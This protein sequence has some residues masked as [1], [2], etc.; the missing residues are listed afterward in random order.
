MK[1]AQDERDLQAAIAGIL[2]NSAKDREIRLAAGRYTLSTTTLTGNL[3]LVGE[4][5]VVLVGPEEAPLF[6]VSAGT[7]SLEGITIE[8]AAG[9]TGVALDAGRVEMREVVV[10]GGTRGVVARGR[11]SLVAEDCAIESVASLSVE[12]HHA[13][14]AELKRV[15]IVTETGVAI[16][17]RGASGLRAEHLEVVA[18]PDKDAIIVERGR[19][20]E[21]VSCRV[22]GGHR[23]LHAKSGQGGRLRDCVFEGSAYPCLFLNGQSKNRPE[24]L[25]AERCT[26]RGSQ[27]GSGVF[28]ERAG[29][30]DT[31]L[32]VLV[33][34]VFERCAGAGAAVEHGALLVVKGG[35]FTENR[36]GV[37]A[38]DRGVL[39]IADATIEGGA[40]S[41]QADKRGTLLA[42]HC[43]FTNAS[44]V[45]VQVQY[46]GQCR[47]DGGCLSTSAL[48]F[49]LGDGWLGIHNATVE[50]DDVALKVEG[51][52]AVVLRS[53][54]ASAAEPAVAVVS[55]EV[56]ADEEAA[57]GGPGVQIF[58][59][60]SGDAASADAI[61]ALVR[62]PPDAWRNALL[63]EGIDV[64]TWSLEVVLEGAGRVLDGGALRRGTLEQLREDGRWF[65]RAVEWL[66]VDPALRGVTTR[67]ARADTLPPL[68]ELLSELDV[69]L[70]DAGSDRFKLRP[71]A[72]QK[73]LTKLATHL[74]MEELP[75][76]LVV[77]F[78]WHDGQSSPEPDHGGLQPGKTF[79]AMSLE[80]IME[81]AMDVH[82]DATRMPPLPSTHLPLLAYP[83]GLVTYDLADGHLYLAENGAPEVEAFDNGRTLGEWIHNVVTMRRREAHARELASTPP[84]ELATEDQ[85]VVLASAGQLLTQNGACLELLGGARPGVG[86][87]A[88]HHV[89]RYWWDVYTSRDAATTIEGLIE[90]AKTLLE[91]NGPDEDVAWE[92]GRAAFVAGSAYVAGLVGR[93]EAWPRMVQ[94]ARLLRRRFVS[95]EHFGDAYA[96]HLGEWEA[97]LDPENAKAHAR[98]ERLNTPFSRAYARLL[99]TGLW[100]QVPWELASEPPAPPEL[101]AAKT[102]KVTP[103]GRGDTSTLAV[104]LREASPGDRL[105]VSPGRHRGGHVAASAFLE[106]V[107]DGEGVVIESLDDA[108]CFA[109]KGGTLILEN[110]TMRAIRRRSGRGRYAV[111]ID[112]GHLQATRCRFEAASIGLLHHNGV[113]RL[114]DC[115]VEGLDNVAIQV[116]RGCFVAER[117]KI[118]RAAVINVQIAGSDTK[119][120]L[121]ECTLAE[122]HGIGLGAYNGAEVEA[123]SCRIHGHSKSNVVVSAPVT[124]IECELSR[125]GE[126]AAKVVGDGVLRLLG[127][128]VRDAPNGSCVY[129]EATSV[130]E[131]R[132]S[133]LH[134]SAGSGLMLTGRAQGRVFQSE[135]FACNTA[136][137]FAREG[138]AGIVVGSRI[139]DCEFGPG[140]WVDGASMQLAGCL[141]ERNGRCGVEVKADGAARV[142]SCRFAGNEGAGVR[143]IEGGSLFLH[144][145]TIADHPEVGI[146]ARGGAVYLR[147]VDVQGCAEIGVRVVSGQL[148]GHGAKLAAGSASGLLVGHEGR[149]ALLGAQL[150]GAEND[151]VIVE[152]GG[153]LV[154]GQ[155]LFGRCG[156]VGLRSS[157][158]TLIVDS[159]LSHCGGDG[160][161]ADGGELT[162]WRC[163]LFDLPGTGVRIVDAR[164]AMFASTVAAVGEDAAV[165]V[166]GSLAIEGSRLE[167]GRGYALRV[168]P[169][170]QT[171]LAGA[172]LQAGQQGDATGAI[173]SVSS[174][175]AEIEPHGDD[176]TL[177]WA[178][179]RQG[180]VTRLAALSWLDGAEVELSAEGARAQDRDALLRVAKLREWLT[181]T[182]DRAHL[183][184]QIAELARWVEAR[185][186]D[187]EPSSP[188]AH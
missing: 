186:E 177:P 97:G 99:T 74:A 61:A 42:E 179:T 148:I 160:A 150:V 185:G 1:R 46:G 171:T 65:Q 101:C 112:G 35:H 73:A 136:G 121:D 103:D 184:D 156:G 91:S 10:R 149:A 143:A 111:T 154:V 100:S 20:V 7:L 140:V 15:R 116:D 49:F 5:G 157:G 94:A 172:E 28:A 158:Q 38:R 69:L 86:V 8:P 89:L 68:G 78:S 27:S 92:A 44:V 50:T 23:G 60:A 107:G 104:A 115:E 24:P 181:E 37:I 146:D 169:E 133:R 14:R 102:W 134:H 152:N 187:D 182:E 59:P 63:A 82:G 21:L 70:P 62:Q 188:G 162:F 142:Q 22:V 174:A 105:V 117:C 114:C 11:S 66:A 135:I 29:N 176:W 84:D 43:S 155:G 108:P 109:V 48:A 145:V 9:G 168:A 77:W 175:A 159:Q 126:A 36:S 130:V 57:I 113:S 30:A 25:V 106:I 124:L 125:S 12:L 32:G 87:A 144:D 18:G 4:D 79:V 2:A 129:A 119:A 110:L 88:A 173:A 153:S 166:S 98:S 47:I 80:E 93:E 118:A 170:A 96:R 178:A 33:D 85:R 83:P 123:I 183:A 45:G 40:A 127:S 139:A 67:E 128:E 58:T 34:C 95:W 75:S 31:A 163:R 137:V 16:A 52:T 53:R 17:Q 3:R 55:G 131:I 90:D 51:G 64:E 151:G 71:G 122:G 76:D 26:F 165:A 120:R 161:V 6:V 81:K 19:D 141:I 72:S 164:V 41:A 39:R 147:D 180:D 54:V 132:G 167:G 13:S 56:W 138:A